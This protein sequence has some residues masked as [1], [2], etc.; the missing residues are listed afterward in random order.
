MP[1]IIPTK[2]SAGHDAVQVWKWASFDTADTA[3]PVAAPGFRDKSMSVVNDIGAGIVEIHGSLMP[4][5]ETPVFGQLKDPQGVALA[6][7]DADGSIEDIET[8]LQ[9]VFS[10]KP[11]ASGTFTNPVDVYLLLS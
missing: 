9:N 8:I 6:L 1:L 7:T 11:V 5:G 2:L 4:P 3:E 10:I